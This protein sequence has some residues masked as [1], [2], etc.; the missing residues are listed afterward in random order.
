MAS[1]QTCQ[2]SPYL[3]RLGRDH[4][5]NIYYWHMLVASICSWIGLY[6]SSVQVVIVFVLSLLLSIAIN[7]K[8]VIGS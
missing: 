7:S 3:V 6:V 2:F 5:A 4:S 1:H 8:E